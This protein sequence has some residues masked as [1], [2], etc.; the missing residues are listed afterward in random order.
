MLATADGAHPPRALVV[1]LPATVKLEL[2]A[3]P[4]RGTRALVGLRRPP[5]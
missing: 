2:L 4:P 1:P 3:R 5:A